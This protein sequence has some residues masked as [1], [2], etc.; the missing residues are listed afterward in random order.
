MV[1]FVDLPPRLWDEARQYRAALRREFAFIVA[2]GLDGT[3]LG[4]RLIEIARTT[5]TRYAD[6]N[7]ES[8]IVIDDALSRGEDSCTVIV[9]VP[10]NLKEHIL[11]AIPVLVEIDQYCRDGAML[12]RPTTPELRRFASWYLGE[13]VGQ[14]DGR[15]PKS[16]RALSNVSG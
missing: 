13:F 4:R 11:G 14:I 16:W 8:E 2:A 5:D 9:E 6:L 15:P 1:V 12:L 10:S 3:A 7:L